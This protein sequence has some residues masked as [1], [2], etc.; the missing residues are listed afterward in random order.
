M[1][2]DGE[3]LSSVVFGIPVVETSL[4]SRA[5]EVE[6]AWL[7]KLAMVMKPWVVL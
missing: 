5:E 3:V 4:G 1:K 6:E 2:A 7:K